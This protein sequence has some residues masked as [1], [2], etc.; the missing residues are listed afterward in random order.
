M[1]ERKATTPMPH[2]CLSAA[3]LPRRL[4]ALLLLS[5]AAVAA[6]AQDLKIGGTGAGLATMR[7]LGEAFARQNPGVTIEVLPSLGSGG[8]VKALL[9]GVVQV[10]VISRPLQ[11]K[12]VAAGA[13]AQ[14]Y[15]RTPFV[16]AS[17]RSTK[18]R[19][20]SVGDLVEIYAGRQERWPDGTPIRL[21]LRPV[22]DSDSEALKAISPAMR[23]AKTAAEQRKGMLFAVTDQEAADALEKMPGSLGPITL[24][25]ALSERR[26]LRI[27]PLDGIAPDVRSLADGSYALYKT[28]LLVTGPRSPAAA[29][30]FVDFARSPAAREI[31]VKNGHWVK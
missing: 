25:L 5:C 12:E 23:E 21:V 20:I 16:F 9:A 3:G 27:L 14:E 7:L 29:K 22:G 31:L 13:V 19:G 15:G 11:E 30:A 10:A 17:H 28:M 18:V 6:P 1:R 26:E 4:F 24:A 2:A 8:G